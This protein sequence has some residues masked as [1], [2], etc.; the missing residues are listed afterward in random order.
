[1]SAIFKTRILII[2]AVFILT[3]PG[4]VFSEQ[5]I[6]ENDDVTARATAIT[7]DG[8]WQHHS[9]DP[10]DDD[11]WVKFDA[12]VD[13]V[14]IIETAGLTDGCDTYIFLYDTDRVTRI[15]QDDESGSE[16]DASLIEFRC[17]KSG[18]YYVY[19]RDFWDKSGTGSYSISV[20]E[21]GS[22][23]LGDAYEPDNDYEHAQQ[24]EVDTVQR[25]TME[26]GD[27]DWYYFDAWEGNEYAIVTTDSNGE[28][29]K[30]THLYLYEFDGVT[31]VDN[32]PGTSPLVWTSTKSNRYYVEVVGDDTTTDIY[33]LTVAKNPSSGK[34]E[35]GRTSAGGCFIRSLSN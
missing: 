27:R 22:G 8:T 1:M 2:A 26:I 31:L 11:D 28:R 23:I 9:I 15:D 18:T 35:P 3:I 29:C 19:I 4:T 13:V 17:R 24:V 25:H 20:R 7:T 5:D 10:A 14:Y 6:Y 32:G 16:V 33:F 30:Y 21:S 12:E 34:E